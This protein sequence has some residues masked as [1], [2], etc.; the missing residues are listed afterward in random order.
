MCRQKY[1][2]T[3]CGTL[4]A[5]SIVLFAEDFS[6]AEGAAKFSDGIQEHFV[7]AHRSTRNLEDR[8]LR[9][10][11]QYRAQGRYELARQ[12][13]AQALSICT[14]EAKIPIIRKELDGIE[15]LLRTMR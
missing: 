3:V 6:Y 5:C 10:A 7:C 1:I 12:S 13:Y 15:L 9:E 8:Y 4:L 14:N 11:R 2:R